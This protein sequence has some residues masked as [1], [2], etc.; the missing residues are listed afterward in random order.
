MSSSDG[1]PLSGPRVERNDKTT[2]EVYPEQGHSANV[3]FFGTTGKNFAYVGVIL[4]P[5]LQ[6]IILLQENS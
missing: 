1:R 5:T 2:S 6:A 3:S 4:N